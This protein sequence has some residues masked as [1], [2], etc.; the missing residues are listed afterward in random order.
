MRVGLPYGV[1]AQLLFDSFA[2]L[3]YPVEATRK[4]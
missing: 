4:E 3:R 2:D 1:V